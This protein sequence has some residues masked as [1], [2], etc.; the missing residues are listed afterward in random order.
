[1]KWYIWALMIVLALL[2]IPGAI[3]TFKWAKAKASATTTTAA[4][5]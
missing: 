3:S 1:M 5:A 4:N 2:A